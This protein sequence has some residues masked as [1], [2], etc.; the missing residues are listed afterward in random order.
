[1]TPL[2]DEQR[3]RFGIGRLDPWWEEASLVGLVPKVLVQIGI[4][5]LLQRLDVVD[6]DQVAVQ[7]HELDARLLEGALR[8]QVTLDARECLVRVVVRLFDQAQLLAL[9]LIQP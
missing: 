8:Q 3:W 7:V 1:M 5:D 2:V 9:A 4:R 6:G